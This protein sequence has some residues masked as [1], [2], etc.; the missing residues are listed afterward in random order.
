MVALVLVLAVGSSGAGVIFEDGFESLDVRWTRNVTGNGTIEIVPGGVEGNCLKMTA[1]GGTTYLSTPLD[2]EEYAGTTIEVVGMVKLENVQMGQEVWATAKFHIGAVL[3][4]Q[5]VVNFA[6][7]WVGTADWAAKKLTA[8]I[9]ENAQRIVLDLGLQNAIGTAYYD[10]LVVRDT[11]GTGRPISLLPICNLGR[12]DG[13]ANDGRG[14]FLDLGMHDLFG[15]PEGSLEGPGITFTIPPDG[16]NKGRTCV[17]LR[18]EQRPNLPAE[19]EPL[20]LNV[21]A[22][23]LHFLLAAAWADTAAQEPCLTCELE[24]ADGQKVGVEMRAGVDI[25]NFDD[26]R[27]FANYRLVWQERNGAGKEVGVGAATWQNPRP[28]VAIKS[29]RIVSA[30]KGVPIVLAVSYLR[31]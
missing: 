29:L 3:P 8:D 21:K 19:T 22:A 4:D 31:R 15:L 5:T 11:S 7:R 26:P 14:S 10:N 30:G 17:V 28:E 16:V 24:Y 9:P 2:P 27:E 13:V 12:S 6:D 20:P 18:G 25:G 1:A 23:S